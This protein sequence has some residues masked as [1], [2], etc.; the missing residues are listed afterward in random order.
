[1]RPPNFFGAYDPAELEALLEQHRAVYGEI[2]EQGKNSP[3]N[4]G[5]G[6]TI[7]GLH[8]LVLEALEDTSKKEDKDV[9]SS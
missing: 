8:G 6:S 1:M 3:P 9:T 4:S 7:P 5:Q 2:A